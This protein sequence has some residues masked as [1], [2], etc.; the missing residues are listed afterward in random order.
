MWYGDR[1]PHSSATILQYTF[2]S[3]FV[4]NHNIFI[5][6]SLAA[7]GFDCAIHMA[8]SL[9]WVAF[10]FY[11]FYSTPPRRAFF[12]L[13]FFQMINR[14]LFDFVAF[15]IEHQNHRIPSIKSS[16]HCRIFH[17]AISIR[18]HC[19]TFQVCDARQYVMLCCYMLKIQHN[20]WFFYICFWLKSLEHLN[21]WHAVL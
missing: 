9:I 18:C 1:T 4:V 14:K 10:W 16:I 5:F 17:I 7:V 6:L 19:S 3:Q 11:S 21:T 12:L 2:R 13:F 20:V 15:A 8:S